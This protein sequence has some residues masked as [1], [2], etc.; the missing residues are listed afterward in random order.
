MLFNKPKN[1][2]GW[3]SK[4]SGNAKKQKMYFDQGQYCLASRLKFVQ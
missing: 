2:C 1:G 4:P 3:F